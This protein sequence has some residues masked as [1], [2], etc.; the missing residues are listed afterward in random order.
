MEMRLEVSCAVAYEQIDKTDIFDF[1]YVAINT[2]KDVKYLRNCLDNEGV[3]VFN[4]LAMSDIKI[5]VVY[6]ETE[7]QKARKAL[8]NLFD[9]E[10]T[11]DVYGDGFTVDLCVEE[12][13]SNSDKLAFYSKTLKDKEDDLE[14]QKELKKAKASLELTKKRIE[15]DSY[16]LTTIDFIGLKG[17]INI[18]NFEKNVQ[19]FLEQNASKD[20]TPFKKIY[21]ELTK[22]NFCHRN[23]ANGLEFDNFNACVENM[24]KLKLHRTM[25]RGLLENWKY[26]IEIDK[27]ARVIANEQ[28][29]NGCPS[30]SVNFL[31]FCL[32]NTFYYRSRS[33]TTGKHLTE[34][35]ALGLYYA[36]RGNSVS[37]RSKT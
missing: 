20:F 5:L 24:Y 31:K 11:F 17:S 3:K 6:G 13:M 29:K 28:F 35:I 12:V 25:F 2:V 4:I 23:C 21:R 7:Q 9:V 18:Y 27:I 19:L 36:K 33:T 22:L 34:L 32:A 37:T 1:Q 26:L 30:L 14:K 8:S 10:N 15:Y 16:N